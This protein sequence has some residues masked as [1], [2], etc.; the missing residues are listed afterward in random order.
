MKSSESFIRRYLRKLSIGVLIL[1][2]LFFGAIFLFGV[3]VHEVFWEREEEMDHYAFDL[4]TT[5]VVNGELTPWMEGVSFFASA[6]FLQVAYPL[7]VLL[8][9]LQ[10]D[11]KR[12]IEIGVIGLG[13]YAVNIFMKWFFRRPRPEDPLLTETVSHYGFPSGHA[14]SGIIFYGLLTYLTWKTGL[15]LKYKY[16]VGF[17]L[18]LFCL[19]IGFSRVYLRV[20][21]LSDVVGGYCIGLAWLV[22]AIGM[23]ERLKRRSKEEERGA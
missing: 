11:W 5:H 4:L 10:K 12:S 16:M 8:Y 17:V 20:H 9:L 22:F 18:L 19:L 23:M 13:G 1:L 6:S 7:V 14:M 21:Y 3:I 2:A 15:A